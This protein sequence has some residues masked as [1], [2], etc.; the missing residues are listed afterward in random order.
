M[1]NKL[2]KAHKLLESQLNTYPLDTESENMG[3][4]GHDNSYSFVKN[5]NQSSKYYGGPLLALRRENNTRFFFIIS[6]QAQ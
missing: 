6:L 5:P 2:N 1:F 4:S 3:L